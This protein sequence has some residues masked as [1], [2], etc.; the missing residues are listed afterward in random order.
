MKIYRE[1]ADAVGLDVDTKFARKSTLYMSDG[2][3]FRVRADG[4]EMFVGNGM[5]DGTHRLSFGTTSHPT[6]WM[7]LLTIECTKFEIAAYDCGEFQLLEDLGAGIFCIAKN[8]CGNGHMRIF[9]L[10]SMIAKR[11]GGQIL[12]ETINTLASAYARA[13]GKRARRRLAS[14]EAYIRGLG[15]RAI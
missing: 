2:G 13:T 6:E 12:S 14:A 15:L 5:G 4:H 3:Q 10:T 1:N 8:R 9:K 11:D 7:C